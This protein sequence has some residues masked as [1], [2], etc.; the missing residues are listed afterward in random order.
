MWLDRDRRQRL[1]L[2]NE[3]LLASH[4]R[5]R[6]RTRV[7]PGAP[8]K[9]DDR[10]VDIRPIVAYHYARALLEHGH[11]VPIGESGLDSRRAPLC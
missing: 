9:C 8:Q 10:H 5:E 6:A 11:N 7:R 4:G 3:R 1:D 2:R